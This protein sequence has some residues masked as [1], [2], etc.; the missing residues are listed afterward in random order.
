[1]VQTQVV[2]VLSMTKL[3]FNKLISLKLTLMATF[4]QNCIYHLAK[5]HDKMKKRSQ[6]VHTKTWPAT[7]VHCYWWKVITWYK[8]ELASC[9]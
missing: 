7:N 4:T 2:L 6:E 1:M 9:L 3:M 5:T 8:I